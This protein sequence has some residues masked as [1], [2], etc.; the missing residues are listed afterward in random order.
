MVNFGLLAA[1][2]VLGVWGTPSTFNSFRILAALLHG[3]QV[4]SVSQTLQCWT[5][6]ASYVRQGD[7]H[8]GH[9]PTFLV[10]YVIIL[11]YYICL[12]C[13]VYALYIY[14][15]GLR[16][17]N[18]WLCFPTVS[19]FSTCWALVTYQMPLL[20]PIKKTKALKTSSTV[21]NTSVHTNLVNSAWRVFINCSSAKPFSRMRLPRAAKARAIPSPIPLV[22]PVT[23]ATFLSKTGC[24]LTVISTGNSYFY[25]NYTVSQKKGYRPLPTIIST[26]VNRFQ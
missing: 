24:T 9:W 15:M 23:S 2:I 26:I 4:V 13:F 6:G 7:H 5:E 19:H 14:Y 8:V 16:P 1:E 11:Y 17:I 25:Y 10:D 20:C 21:K 22:D 3:S 12:L 18:C